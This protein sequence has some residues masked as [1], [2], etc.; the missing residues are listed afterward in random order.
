MIWYN[1][2]KLAEVIMSKKLTLESFIE[3]ANLK[4]DNK[5]NYSKSIYISI[6][7]KVIIIC[8]IHGEF[9]QSAKSHMDGF[10]CKQCSLD[11][12]SI[13]SRKNTSDFIKDAKEIHGNK[14]DYSLVKYK[15]A[16]EKIV[17]ICPIHGEFSQT[18]NSH[19][20]GNGCKRCANI[21]NS[22]RLKNT[23]FDFI[24]KANLKHNNKYD[25]SK[26]DYK[27]W[28]DYIIIICKEH[29]EFKQKAGNHL[30]GRGCYK[31]GINKSKKDNDFF[32]KKANIIHNNKYDYSK[33]DYKV[34]NEKVVIICP[35]HGEF[36]QLPSNHLRGHGCSTCSSSKGEDLISK[37]LN[38]TQ[39]VNIPQMTFPDCKDI[40]NLKFDF[41]LPE[42]KT[43]IEY[44]GIQHYEEVLTKKYFGGIKELRDRQKKDQI[45]RDWCKENGYN[46]IEISYKNPF[47]IYDYDFNLLKLK[48]EFG[49][50]L[51]NLDYFSFTKDIDINYCNINYPKNNLELLNNSDKKL[52]TIYSDQLENKY[53]IIKSRLNTLLG[54]NNIIYARKCEL[55]ELSHKELKDF[56]DTNHIQGNVNSNIRYGLFYNNELIASM[57]F[58]KLRKALGRS[59]REGSY[60]LVRFCNKLNTTVVGAAGKLLSHFINTA[61][62]KEIISYADR[63]WSDGNLYETLGFKFIMNTSSNYY[64]IINN[65]RYNRFKFRKSNLIDNGFDK[66]KTEFEIMNELGF[67]KLFDCGSKLYKLNVY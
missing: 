25:Y 41:Y 51:N 50:E 56:L 3:R 15:T 26:V 17:I 13:I 42:L 16:K 14:Y 12:R 27:S 65:K 23:I 24:N 36:L 58:C 38:D 29:G 59:H 53:E 39:V 43:L 62:P 6:F 4:H 11:K 21:L 67:S 8:P 37:Y 9:L 20:N 55:K 33:V 57:S 5:Y 60:E 31:C 40:S 52:I 30:S 10:G 28:D 63:N 35:I 18:A 7:E 64:Y 19:L 22:E 46:L 49:L 66:N 44:Q 47:E 54:K 61:K 45:K 1:I 34:T 2:I 48:Q 32:I